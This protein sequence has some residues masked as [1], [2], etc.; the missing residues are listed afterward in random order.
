M[1]LKFPRQFD[2]QVYVIARRSNH[3]AGCRA[4]GCLEENV[5]VVVWHLL[6]VLKMAE[7]RS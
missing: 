1:A 6:A 7:L 3:K 5:A 4:A 2:H